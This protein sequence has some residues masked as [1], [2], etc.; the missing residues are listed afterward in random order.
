MQWYPV[1]QGD[2]EEKKRHTTFRVWSRRGGGGGGGRG[3]IK[4]ST[5]A[6]GIFCQSLKIKKT[7]EC[8]L[9]FILVY[10][11]CLGLKKLSG[12]DFFFPVYD[13]LGAPDNINNR[14][15]RPFC[16]YCTSGMNDPRV[17]QRRGGTGLATQTRI[18]H[19]GLTDHDLSGLSTAGQSSS[20]PASVRGC[21]GSA[22]SLTDPT[23][24]A[25]ARSCRFTGGPIRQK[26][27]ATYK[28]GIYLP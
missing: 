25:C 26:S 14:S 23:Q 6:G 3:Q 13:T 11:P 16:I 21:A 18:A 4:R 7:H 12:V 1:L 8:L 22:H 19:L 24:E 9:G 20:L 27:Q 10:P 28:S 5:R 17:S 15:R 2:S